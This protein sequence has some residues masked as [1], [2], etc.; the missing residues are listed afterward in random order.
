MTAALRKDRQLA[1]SDSHQDQIFTVDVEEHFQVTAFENSV[2]ITEWG[3]LPSRVEANVDRILQLLADHGATGTFFTVGWVADRHPGLV[4]RIARAGHELA[5]H[6]WWHRRVVTQSP[7][8]FRDD[9][10]RTRELLTDL[11]GQPVFGFRAPSFSLG[12]QTLWA[13]EVLLEESYRYDSSIF[14]IRRPD[15][16]DPTAPLEPYRI[17]TAAGSLL[18]LPL[19][20]T[21]LLGVRVPAA[22][23]GYFRQL[24]YGLTRRAFREHRDGGRAGVFYI[25]PWEIDPDQP[26]LPAPLLS[27][28]RH[29]PGLRRT[30]RKLERLVAEFSFRSIAERY[31]I[32]RASDAGVEW[33]PELVLGS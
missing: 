4:R 18:E 31:G 8:Q 32:E 26:R 24:P 33:T 12:P 2:P 10:R 21:N 3:H 6:T 5:S 19:A 23:G 28:A 30:W 11:S 15:Y 29:Y 1:S 20:T 7:E 27:R 17:T 22:G 13:Y 16:G 25:H 9:V 14:P